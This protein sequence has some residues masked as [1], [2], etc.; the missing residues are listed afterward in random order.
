MFAATGYVAEPHTAIGVAAARAEP[1]PHGV[2]TVAMATAHLA[3][4]PDP[5]ERATGHRPALPPRLADIFE[6]EERFTVLPND[7]AA[8][9]AQVRSLARRNA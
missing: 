5:V 7:L 1:P 4:F 6:R 8:V 2:P 3:K 9:E